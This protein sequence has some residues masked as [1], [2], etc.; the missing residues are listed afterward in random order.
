[1]KQ[2]INDY[3]KETKDENKRIVN[4][5]NDTTVPINIFIKYLLNNKCYD[6]VAYIHEKI[7]NDLGYINVTKNKLSCLDTSDE[8]LKYFID[9]G[10]LRFA[11]N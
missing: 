11:E 9:T 5:L 2:Y 4:I 7:F 10:A 8:P 3:L 6:F 1:M